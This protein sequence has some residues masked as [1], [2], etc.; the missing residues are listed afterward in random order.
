VKDG[1][2]LFVLD[3]A[4]A[5]HAA[6]IMHSIHAAAPDCESVTFVT[7]IIASRLTSAASSCSFRLSVPAGRS[8]RTM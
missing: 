5:L 6:H 8:G 3:R 2:V 1:L 4:H 7:P